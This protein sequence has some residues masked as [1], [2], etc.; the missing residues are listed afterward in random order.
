MATKSSTTH[1]VYV[2]IRRAA[3]SR[4]SPSLVKARVIPGEVMVR[5]GDVINFVSLDTD[6]VLFVP[7]KDL[8]DH[9][10][11]QSSYFT[12]TLTIKTP[13]D[14]VTINPAYSLLHP[15]PLWRTKG[16]RH[17]LEMIEYI[18]Y[19]PAINDF[20]EGGSSPRIIIDE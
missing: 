4:V 11:I 7:R 8:F 2:T 15:F 6:L 20:A 5:P 18:V 1:T 10:S 19:C 13:G 12:Q 3:V 14:I 17:R 16:K 9:N